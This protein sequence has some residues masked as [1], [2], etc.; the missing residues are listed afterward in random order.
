MST[1]LLI[2]SCERRKIPKRGTNPIVE[3][4]RS[5]QFGAQEHLTDV[6]CT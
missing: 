2:Q 4:G 6:P 5:V 1:S 3:D